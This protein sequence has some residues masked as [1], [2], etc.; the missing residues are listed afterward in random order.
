MS[1]HTIIWADDDP[2]DLELFKGVL[3][4]ITNLYDILECNNGLEVI[5]CLKLINEEHFPCLIILDLNMPVLDGK[6]TLIQLKSHPSYQSIPVVVFTTSNSE[7][8]KDFCTRNN[9]EMITKPPTYESLKDVI[10]QI[11]SKCEH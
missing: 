2:D 4:E 7:P 3:N 10:Q 5:E 1:K 11:L 8:D 6:Q 9:T